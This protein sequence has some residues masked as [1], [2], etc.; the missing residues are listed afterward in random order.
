MR[1]VK[2]IIFMGILLFLIGDNKQNTAEL[3]LGF[4]K[5]KWKKVKCGDEIQIGYVIRTKEKS[6]VQIEF[7]T[8]IL[9]PFLVGVR[10]QSYLN[11]VI[12]E[13]TYFILQDDYFKQDV[14]NPKGKIVEVFGTAEIAGMSEEIKNLFRNTTEITITP[15]LSNLLIRRF[16]TDEPN[17][18]YDIP[19]DKGYIL[20]SNSLPTPWLGLILGE[21]GTT[22]IIVRE[23][24]IGGPSYWAGIKDGDEIIEIDGKKVEDLDFVSYIKSLKIGGKVKI[25]VKRDNKMLYLDVLVGKMLP[26][27]YLCPP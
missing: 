15:I 25:G 1:K 22:G 3:L 18:I 9:N 24:I 26:R 6:S 20:Y 5:L 27:N 10:K 8:E 4:D 7:R 2:I 21:R 11:K 14:E 19:I 17:R 13:T 16:V 12:G 23:A